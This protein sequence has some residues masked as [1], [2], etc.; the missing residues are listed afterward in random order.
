[1]DDELVE[2]IAVD[3]WLSVTDDDFPTPV[4]ASRMLEAGRDAG[5]A[6]SEMSGY[7]FED[8]EDKAWSVFVVDGPRPL[9]VHV[10]WRTQK[11]IAAEREVP[12]VVSDGS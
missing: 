10:D 1:M 2:A 5:A 11:L 3:G 9:A 12:V 8:D 7:E 4:L 6:T